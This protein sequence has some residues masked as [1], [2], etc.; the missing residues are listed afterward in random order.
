MDGYETA[1]RIRALPGG[2][3]RQ[4]IAIT[5]WGQASDRERSREAGFKLHLTKP[6][7]LPVLLE[8]LKEMHPTPPP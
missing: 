7:S 2:G 1:R 6:V 8:A 5:G 3:A 4:L